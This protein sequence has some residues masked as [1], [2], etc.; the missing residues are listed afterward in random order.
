[1]FILKTHI[2]VMPGPRLNFKRFKKWLGMPPF[3]KM[4]I[5]TIGGQPSKITP[6]SPA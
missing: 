4:V 2:V 3:A 5:G 6:D 1:M